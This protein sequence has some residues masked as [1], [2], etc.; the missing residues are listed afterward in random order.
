LKRTAVDRTA[1]RMTKHLYAL[2]L[3]RNDRR[4]DWGRY[5]AGYV[6]YGDVSLALIKSEFSM[7]V[8]HEVLFAALFIP[9]FLARDLGQGGQQRRSSEAFFKKLVKTIKDVPDVDYLTDEGFQRLAE[10]IDRVAVEYASD[11]YGKNTIDEFYKNWYYGTIQKIFEYY[12]ERLAADEAAAK[13]AEAIPI[14]DEF[15]ISFQRYAATVAT[16]K[17]ARNDPEMAFAALH[18]PAILGGVLQLDI[19]ANRLGYAQ[20]GEPQNYFLVEHLCQVIDLRPRFVRQFAFDVLYKGVGDMDAVERTLSYLVRVDYLRQGYTALWLGRF[21][22]DRASIEKILADARI[23]SW[24]KAS[25]A[26]LIKDEGFSADHLETLYEQI[27]AQDPTEWH[28]I[29]EYCEYLEKKKDYRKAIEMIDRWLKQGSG[30]GITIV[31]A[32]VFKA[33]MLYLSSDYEQAW[34][35]IEPAIKSY[36]SGAMERGAFI[37]EKLGKYAPAVELARKSVERYPSALHSRLVLAQ[38]YWRSGA[39]KD[40]AETLKSFPLPLN[41]AN[42]RWEIAPKFRE[43]FAEKPV[44]EAVN[45]FRFLAGEKFEPQF[46]VGIAQEFGRKNEHETAFRMVDLLGGEGQS[47]IARLLK[48]YYYLKRW[49]GESEALPWLKRRLPEGLPDG[50]LGMLIYN[51]QEDDLLWTLIDD[52]DDEPGGEYI[53]L[54]RAAA[55]VRSKNAA[56]LKRVGDEYRGTGTFY[57]K[58]TNYL[59]GTLSED[60]LLAA[61]NNGKR[62]C[63]GGYFIGLKA[64][65]D[66]DLRKASDWFQIVLNTGLMN[67]GEYHWAFSQAYDLKN[68]ARSLSIPWEEEI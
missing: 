10:S 7:A 25:G 40:A 56:L 38:I 68:R 9:H 52:P 58:V 12:F 54:L 31:H 21:K 48:G 30:A 63:E 1:D 43:V 3:A 49:K 27:I 66:G 23:V 16:N 61:I 5:V 36:Q 8:L 34:R 6:G 29:N 60:D 37:L 53:W 24:Q 44:D 2:L 13:F 67:N 41:A 15:L 46:I 22:K 50:V 45:A 64:Q 65:A 28:N 55:A 19:Y 26:G 59:R 62:L 17:M 57:D 35:V 39:Y 33:R 18:N 14:S 32:T 20:I 47:E 42:W 4:D 51:E 11:L